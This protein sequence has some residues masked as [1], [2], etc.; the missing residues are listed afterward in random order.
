MFFPK[1][2]TEI[3]LV[4]PSGDLVAVMK[5]ISNQGIFQTADSSYMTLQNES[6][7][8]DGWQE[9]V[10][11]YAA[12]EHRIQMLMQLVGM[13][14]GVPSKKEFKS[15]IDLKTAQINFEEIENEVKKTSDL[16]A[17]GGKKLEEMKS[18]IDQLEPF[19][20][21]DIDISLLRN[22]RFLFSILG[23]I[24]NDNIERLQTSLERI[25]FIFLV[26]RQ[27][28]Q[29][30]IVWLGG[31]RNNSEIL[32]RAARSAYL[33]PLSLPEGYLGTPGKIIQLLNSEIKETQQ[34][35]SG[36]EQT[37]SKLRGHY[38]NQLQALLWDVRMSRMYANAIVHFGHLRYTY[39]IIGWVPTK[40]LAGFTHNLKK[41]SRDA[42]L[43]T[44]PI[45][46]SSTNQSVPVGLNS[47]KFL[48][49]F[50]MLVTTYGQPR[51]NEID[52]TWLMTFLFPLLYGAMFGDAGQGLVLAFLGWLLSSRKVKALRSLAGLGGLITA[53][54]LSATLF[55]FLYGSLFGFENV[56][57]PVW[58][59]PVNNILLILEIAIAAGIILLSLGFLLGIYNAWAARDWGELLFDHHGIAGII[60]YWSLL[61]LAGSMLLLHSPVLS[62]I[63]IIMAVFS[64]IVI[65]FS[66]LLKNLVEGHHP[67]IEGGIGT[68]IFQAFFKIF[69]TV[70]SFLSNS[71]SWVRVGAFAVAH[72]GLSAAFFILAELASPV[73]GMG[74]WIVLLFGNIFIVGFEGLI[75]GIQTMRLSYYEFFGKFFHGGGLKYE[76]LSLRTDESKF[77]W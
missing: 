76:P 71:F 60:L 2:M 14:E 21:L 41:I 56:L 8:T 19:S 1:E 40:S 72:G 54:G 43:D 28:K 34:K 4:V 57:K 16:L 30:S 50:Q 36:L 32:V 45:K 59:S 20:E 10:S 67:L 29:K 68:Y 47:P 12:L 38:Q 58:I 44:Y 23:I 15:F 64:G 26:L 65:I 62:T 51:Y 18:T 55:G 70:I 63:A 74:Y 48:S 69:E 5:S 9:K 73:K 17:S 35:Q 46:R 7:S 53:C 52:P 49:S 11:G 22:P 42:I 3:Q 61:G 25:P 75:V 37:L 77:P 13:D 27:D 6:K 33:N 66:D 24:P 39:L 31:S